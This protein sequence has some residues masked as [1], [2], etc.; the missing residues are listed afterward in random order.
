MALREVLR[1]RLQPGEKPLAMGAADTAG[2]GWRALTVLAPTLPVGMFWSSRLLRRRRVLVLTDR[3]LL[4][5]PPDRPVIDPCWP[6]WNAEIPLSQCEIR[7][8]GPRTYACT[9][10]EGRFVARVRGRWVG[11]ALEAFQAR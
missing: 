8:I 11:A 3:R 9:F 1:E 7:R 2:P 10:P 5:L 6:R 4:I